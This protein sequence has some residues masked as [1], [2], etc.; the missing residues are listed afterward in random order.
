M[1]PGF[2]SVRRRAGRLAACALVA[3]TLNARADVMDIA[4]DANGR[5][6]T[7]LSVAPGQLAEVC[8][9]LAQGQSVAWSF[10]A[11]K[12]VNFNIHYHVGKQVLYPTKQDGA[13]QL[14]GSLEVS[15]DQDYC[16]MWTNQGA[17]AA[18]VQLTLKR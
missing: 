13:S 16:W 18:S 15:L 10:S 5:F 11:D 2:Q 8:G 6:E 7:L 1:T 4:W 14:D 12:P 17:A 9:T 3:T